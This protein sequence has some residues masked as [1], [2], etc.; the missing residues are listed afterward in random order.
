M[1]FYKNT[2]D[3]V[4]KV[5]FYSKNDRERIK[6][7]RNSDKNSSRVIYLDLTDA[8]VLNNKDFYLH[9][10]DVIYVEPL[11]KKFYSVNNL[12]SAISFTISAVTLYFLIINN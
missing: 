12:S 9:P 1:I 6:I 10:Q 4:S 7:I 2:D 11:K 8:D 3:L 5:K